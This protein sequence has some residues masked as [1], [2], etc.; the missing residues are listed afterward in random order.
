MEILLVLREVV[1]LGSQGCRGL[2]VGFQPFGASHGSLKGIPPAPHPPMPQ[3]ASQESYR[4]LYVCCDD[5]RVVMASWTHDYEVW[6][7]GVEGK[8]FI[9]MKLEPSHSSSNKTV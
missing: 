3:D 8:L 9:S 2:Y 1:P 6:L 7:C 4:L 5:Q